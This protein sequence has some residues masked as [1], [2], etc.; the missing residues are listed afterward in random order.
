M[1]SREFIQDKIDSARAKVEKAQASVDRAQKKL[2]SIPEKLAKNKFTSN[3]WADYK[4]DK[5]EGQ[6]AEDFFT[7]RYTYDLNVAKEKLEAAQKSLDK[8]EAMMRELDDKASKRNIQ[9]ILDFLEEWKNKV[10]DWVDE[11]AHRK[12][13]LVKSTKEDI[14]KEV[15]RFYPDDVKQQE[16]IAGMFKRLGEEED[17]YTRAFA[18]ARAERLEAELS[19]TEMYQECQYLVRD[20][21]ELKSIRKH[22][23]GFGID[24][25]GNYDR[26][27]LKKALDQE[28]EHKYDEI[29]DKVQKYVG[30]ITNASNLSVGAKGELNGIVNGTEG[31]ARVETIGAGGYNIQCYHFRTLV[32]PIRKMREGFS[33]NFRKE[34]GK[35]LPEYY[36]KNMIV[37]GDSSGNYPSFKDQNKA[38]RVSADYAYKVVYAFKHFGTAGDIRDMIYAGELPIDNQEAIEPLGLLDSEEWEEICENEGVGLLELMKA[39]VRENNA[40]VRAKAKEERSRLN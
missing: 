10:L 37:E 23:K 24:S 18:T 36:E 9:P 31:S 7:E 27:D 28:A 40:K 3:E 11:N 15:Q 21:E 14:E 25:K 12:A 19:E 17:Y 30:E 2:D 39:K 35:Y 32:N 4:Y 8:F 16:R 5:E 13:E 29:V 6:T 20:L 38:G 1:A 22:T 34:L 33:M 26:E